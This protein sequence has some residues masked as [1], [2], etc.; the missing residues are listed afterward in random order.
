MKGLKTQHAKGINLI[1]FIAV[2]SFFE[3][4]HDNLLILLE[5]FFK[6][7]VLLF[8]YDFLESPKLWNSIFTCIFANF[9]S[10]LIAVPVFLTDGFYVLVE[11]YLV[12]FGQFCSIHHMLFNFSDFLSHR[13]L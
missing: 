10:T 8:Q 4:I 9:K 2:L 5:K 3:F 1:E 11:F 7:S 13:I 12:A 6:L